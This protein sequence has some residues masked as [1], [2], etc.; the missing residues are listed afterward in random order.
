[1][2]MNR[3]QHLSTATSIASVAG[4]MS[5]SPSARRQ[6]LYQSV[7]SCVACATVAARRSGVPWVCAVRGQAGPRQDGEALRWC[8]PRAPAALGMAGRR[9]RIVLPRLAADMLREERAREAR[10]RVADLHAERQRLRVRHRALATCVGGW[11]LLATPAFGYRPTELYPA[12]LPTT[13]RWPFRDEGARRAARRRA[14]ARAASPA[15]AQGHKSRQYGSS[16][17][18][19]SQS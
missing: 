14:A 6:R 17:S 5:G 10:Q 1:M 15:C 19:T 8:A 16:G 9:T 11:S 3:S 7:A 2:P 12:F 4:E 13:L 18:A